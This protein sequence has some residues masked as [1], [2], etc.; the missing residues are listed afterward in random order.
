VGE[1]FHKLL[2]IDFGGENFREFAGC[3]THY[4]SLHGLK[5]KEIID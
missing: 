5:Q 4:R 3:H 2:E 1:N